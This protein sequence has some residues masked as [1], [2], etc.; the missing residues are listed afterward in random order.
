MDLRLRELTAEL[1][2]LTIYEVR[3]IAREVRAFTASGKKNEII[4]SILRFARAEIDAKPLTV[5][6]APP[7]SDKYDERLV[8]EIR[9]IRREYVE[10]KEGGNNVM[11]VS[12]GKNSVGKPFIG[13]LKRDGGDYSLYSNNETVRVSQSFITRYG[14]KTGDKVKGTVKLFS[15]DGTRALSMLDT[16]NGG[17]PSLIRARKE[18]STL[19]RAYPEKRL[20]VADG[21]ADAACRIIDLFAPLAYGQRAFISAP[22]NGG[23]TTLLKKIARSIC[24]NY[25]KIKLIILLPAGKPEDISDFRR[26]FKNAESFVS[27]FGTDENE[28]RTIC[29][30]AFDYAKRQAES[31]LDAVVLSDGLFA[32]CGRSYAKKLLCSAICAVEGGSVTA[33]TTIAQGY[34]E[35]FDAVSSAN[36]LITVS[37]DLIDARVYPAID[38]KKCYANREE[39]LLGTDELNAVNYLRRNADAEEIAELINGT[40]DNNQ[41]IDRYKNG[42]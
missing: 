30:L 38:A 14:L 6:G 15:D 2:K 37:Q 9:E 16:V 26:E 10:K 39:V 3:Q 1:E 12:D 7:K 24:A 35:Y 21:N 32:A 20:K 19:T 5:R 13:Y 8:A 36:A 23:K 22:A 33:I 11:S 41:I 42:R 27:D 40:A 28:N 25:P 4:D 29:T 34:P 17:Q 18:F 31:G